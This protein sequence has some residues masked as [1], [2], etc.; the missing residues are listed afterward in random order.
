M[1]ILS[2][3][4]L[5]FTTILYSEWRF[6][7]Y[8]EIEVDYLHSA[9]VIETELEDYIIIEGPDTTDIY[10]SDGNIL[11]SYVG[12]G[13]KFADLNNN[14]TIERYEY[15]N[16]TI[17]VYEPFDSQIASIP[18][19]VMPEESLLFWGVLKYPT[20][21][22]S[23]PGVIFSSYLTADSII[24]EMDTIDEYYVSYII[25]HIGK[26]RILNMDNE[27]IYEQDSGKVIRDFVYDDSSL[28]LFCVDETDSVDDGCDS[29]VRLIYGDLY[30]KK[31]TDDSIINT[32]FNFIAIESYGGGWAEASYDTSR[33]VDKFFYDNK[34]FFSILQRSWYS[35]YGG[36]PHWDRFWAFSFD[37]TLTRLNRFPISLGWECERYA[38]IFCGNFM[39]P[40]SVNLLYIDNLSYLDTVYAAILDIEGDTLFTFF[41]TM[42]FIAKNGIKIHNNSLDK[43]LIFSYNRNKI[44]I[45]HIQWIDKINEQKN[46]IENIYV[47]VLPNPFNSVCE[48]TVPENAKI[49]IYDLRGNNIYNPS[50]SDCVGAVPLNKG[51]IEIA[52]QSSKGIIWQPD[53]TIPSGI[54]FVRAKMPNGQ[55]ASRRI[56][57]MK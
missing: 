37:D 21:S 15:I 30:L 18:F 52:E 49:E 26:V 24:C 8:W 14:C 54:Y 44:G 25:P 31:I 28:Y 45:Y 1:K 35:G 9:Y 40:D 34:L 53:E 22:G 5:L 57:Y 12:S 11:Y 51:N 47:N 32:L 27:I 55:T 19:S 17:K 39:S 16:D 6:M 3:F 33:I 42:D 29:Y 36:P 43:D 38:H 23:I 2:T 10:D 56:V 20:D 41:D 7:P 46:K 4:L 48:I 13:K 50:I